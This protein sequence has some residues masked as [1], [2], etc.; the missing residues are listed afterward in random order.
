[1]S[2]KNPR[3]VTRNDTEDGPDFGHRSIQRAVFGLL[4]TA[5][6]TPKGLH[7]LYWLLDS[8]DPQHVLLPESIDTE[9]DR[10]SSVQTAGFR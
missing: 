2:A 5:P 10:W 7:T 8:L 4:R 6:T 1:M 3:L 9:L